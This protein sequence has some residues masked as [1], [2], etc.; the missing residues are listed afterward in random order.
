METGIAGPLNPRHPWHEVEA[1][2]KAGQ[3][4]TL[5][6]RHAYYAEQRR[7]QTAESGEDTNQREAGT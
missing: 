1:E 3:R 5:S 6:D 2:R 7:R 4:K